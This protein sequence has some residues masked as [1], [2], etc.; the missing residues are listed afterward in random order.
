MKG[1]PWQMRQAAHWMLAAPRVST[2]AYPWCGA[3]RGHVHRRSIALWHLTIRPV[4]AVLQ[5]LRRAGVSIAGGRIPTPAAMVSWFPCI[6]RIGAAIQKRLTIKLRS[7]MRD[8]DFVGLCVEVDDALISGYGIIKIQLLY[9][10][11]RQL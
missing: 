7:V 11:S 1:I 3:L 4:P 2:L 6:M 5:G 8:D 9:I 10:S